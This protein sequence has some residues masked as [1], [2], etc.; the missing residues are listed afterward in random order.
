MVA[1][2]SPARYDLF[3]GAPSYDAA[4]LAEYFAPLSPELFDDPRC[5]AT[6]RRL[7]ADDPDAIAAVADVDRSQVREALALSP[8]QRLARAV[9]RWNSLARI[10]R[11]G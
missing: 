5:G 11:G 3:M 9:A 8:E 10:R 6:L 4:T 7:A 2:A 1:V